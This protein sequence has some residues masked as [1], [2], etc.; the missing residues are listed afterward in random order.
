MTREEVEGIVLDCLLKIK[1]AIKQYPE[2]SSH[3]VCLSVWQDYVSAF[4][5]TEDETDYTL[6]ISDGRL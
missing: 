4:Q 6:Y 3:V 1:E 2:A 5:H